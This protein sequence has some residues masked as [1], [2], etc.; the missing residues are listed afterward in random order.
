M[1]S[2]QSALQVTS[3]RAAEERREKD[4]RMATLENDYSE[5]AKELERCKQTLGSRDDEVARLQSK[6]SK[7][8]IELDE[9]NGNI[10]NRFE[11]KVAHGVKTRAALS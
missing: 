4:D 7:E 5:I 1:E 11:E 2:L 3:A 6:L 10:D 9:M 8:R